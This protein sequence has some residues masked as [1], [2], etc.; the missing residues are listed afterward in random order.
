MDHLFSVEHGCEFLWKYWEANSL[1]FCGAKVLVPLKTGKMYQLPQASDCSRN[2]TELQEAQGID[3]RDFRYSVF[4]FALFG[5]NE[6]FLG[7]QLSGDF[8]VK[9][10]KATF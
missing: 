4:N 5:F 1:I 6:N 7:S 9:Y 3:G 10:F 8:Y 2:V